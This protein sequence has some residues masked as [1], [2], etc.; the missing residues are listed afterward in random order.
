MIAGVGRAVVVEEL[1]K[2]TASNGT[3]YGALGFSVAID[4]GIVVSGAPYFGIPDLRNPGAAYVYNALNGSQLHRLNG[5]GTGSDRWGQSVSIGGGVAVVGVPAA[6][7]NG[8]RSGAA[9][10]VDVDSGSSRSRFSPDDANQLQEFGAAVSTDG[11]NVLVGAPGFRDGGSQT[12]AAYVFDAATGLR[13]AVLL[14]D[15]PDEWFADAVGISGPNAIVGAARGGSA[16]V[17]YVFDVSTGVQRTKLF[18]SDANDDKR[19]GASVAIDGGTAIVGAPLDDAGV[20]FGAGAAYLF[21]VETGAQL[22]KLTADDARSVEFFGQ[23]VSISGNL[24]LVGAPAHLDNIGPGSAYLFDVTTGAQIAKFT[25][26]DA[27]FLDNFGYSVSI[28]QQIMVVGA[29]GDDDNGINSGAAYVFHIRVPEPASLVA[30][31][32]A[33]VPATLFLRSGRPSV[34]QHD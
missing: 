22:A 28:D 10:Q 32:C 31:A 20:S 2:L 30:M 15:A 23:S 9:Y 13:K 11:T 7:T 6:Y 16:G 3:A 33:F 27:D 34:L 4:G 19:F 5:G 25:S 17:A 1:H 8:V 18:P 29:Y 26:S 24:A 14:P 12:G 21:N